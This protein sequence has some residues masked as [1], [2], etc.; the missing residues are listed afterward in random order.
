MVLHDA[1]FSLA[2]GRQTL[3]HRCLSDF[4]AFSL[5]NSATSVCTSI[6]QYT[7]TFTVKGTQCKLCLIMFHVFMQVQHV[8]IRTPFSSFFHLVGMLTTYLTVACQLLW[9]GAYSKY[10]PTVLVIPSSTLQ[11]FKVRT[12]CC[13]RLC[14]N[15][16]KTPRLLMEAFGFESTRGIFVAHH[17]LWYAQQHLTQ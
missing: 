16:C 1:N 17:R 8:N 15:H 5:Q 3:Q 12:Q 10:Y 4:D 13:S 9:Q 2:H 7:D 11:D 14:S 6:N